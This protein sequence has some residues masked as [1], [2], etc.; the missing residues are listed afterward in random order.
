MEVE[1]DIDSVNVLPETKY[2]CESRHIAC[3]QM[4]L[5]P[6]QYNPRVIYRFGSHSR[7]PVS[8][9]YLFR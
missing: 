1:F 5:V 4:K 6:N 2:E 9:K 7:C 3:V 8:G